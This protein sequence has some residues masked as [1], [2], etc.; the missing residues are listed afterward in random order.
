MFCV[1][2][3]RGKGKSFEQIETISVVKE[4]KVLLDTNIIIDRETKDPGNK[5]IGKLFWWIDKLGYK[6]CI[7]Q[8][9]VNE[10]SR[11][12]NVADTK[13]RNL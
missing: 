8:V 3:G 12:Q 13:E 9:T 2:I 11:N 10:I 6:K 1:V 4:M 5:D 7:H